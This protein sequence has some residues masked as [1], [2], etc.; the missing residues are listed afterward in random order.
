MKKLLYLLLFA[1]FGVSAQIVGI[2]IATPIIKNNPTDNTITGYAN[3]LNGGYKI[4][5]DYHGRDS[6]VTA[7]S[8]SLQI[9]MLVYEQ[10]VDSTYRWTGSS[11][12]SISTGSDSTIYKTDGTLIGDRTIQTNFHGFYILDS[13][14][15]V[16]SY[17]FLETNKLFPSLQ[18]N[19]KDNT[20]NYGQL[21]ITPST[22]N[23]S[24]NLT[25]GASSGFTID[26][27]GIL[28]QNAINNADLQ[29]A[30]NYGANLTPLSYITKYEADSLY[31]GG[32]G[33]VTSVSGTANRITSTG[34]ATPVIDISA[35]YVGQSSI[36][37]LGTITTGVWNGTAISNAN[38]ANSS[39]TINGTSI[40]LGASGTV[41]AA[42]GTL[43]GTT[44]NS[45]VVTSSLTSI[46]TLSS[47]AVPWSL[48]TSTPTTISG[49]G[50]T[51]GLTL[52]GAQN[53]SNK[54]FRPANTFQTGLGTAGTDSLVVKTSGALK[55]ISPTYYQIAGTYVTAIGVTTANGISG[56][57]SGG[58]TPNLT[59]TLGNIVPT[60][61]STTIKP[62][63][64]YQTAAGTAGTDSVMV[65]HAGGIVD[66]I[67]PTYYLASTTAASTYVPQTTT[68]AG[69]P[70]S[71]NVTLATLTPGSS[72]TN[73]SGAS[74][75]NG[76]VAS[77]FDINVANTNTFTVVQNINKAALGTTPVDALFL[78]NTTAAAVGA[79]QV[80]PFL[81]QG[82]FGWGTTAGTSQ[83]VDFYT[84]VLPVQSTVPT[85]TWNLQS[86]IAGGAKTTQFSVTSAG[87]GT[88]AGALSISGNLIGVAAMGTSSTI[89]T[90]RT[91]LAATTLNGLMETNTTLAT[92]GVPLQVSPSISFTGSVWNTT[93]VAAANQ[94]DW[95][96][97]A[98]GVSGTTPTTSWSLFSSLVTNT[99]ASYTERLRLDNGGNLSL[100]TG[101]LTLST[102][103]SHFIITEGSNAPTGQTTLV[104]GTKAITITG[105]TTSGRA[106]VQL[107]TPTGVTLTT[108]YQAVCTSNTLTIQANVAAGT[109]NAADG[110]VLNYW[111]TNY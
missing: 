11:W 51:D 1:S 48:I 101:N 87:V 30:F 34:G 54:I 26:N 67:S 98:T 82:G 69:S 86:S 33:G 24:L 64:V 19:L 47:G 73:S 38:L 49:Y 35:S 61:I 37:N 22:V 72:L 100:L 63:T 6:L 83:A 15:S 92:A 12:T 104:S 89:T 70:L 36:T 27:T 32:S 18:T 10:N 53:V 21:N 84:Y 9:G 43:T 111:L 102:A 14:A 71:G 29:A 108:A 74:T 110:S 25:S 44:L 85:G 20:G 50:I 94:F 40:N 57:S 39:T 23:F 109:I 4:V 3:L 62:A 7:Y 5:P 65:K 13:L 52:T 90:T 91:G 78:Q 55:A 95:R 2:K 58:T 66:A 81:H 45:T 80:S 93:S 31:T 99:T 68:V 96:M 60:T 28:Y 8:T 75:Y 88:F 105:L 41:T 46:G 16:G 76:S 56:S 79:Q 17:F 77:T 59:L 106:F 42:A 107:V 103:G 97:G